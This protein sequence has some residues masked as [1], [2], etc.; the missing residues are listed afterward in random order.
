MPT[1]DANNNIVITVT[2]IRGLF[3]EF[4]DAL[5]YPDVRVQSCITVA[6]LY[7]STKNY[8]DIGYDRRVLLIELMTAHLLKL[9]DQT[10]AGT[11]GGAVGAGGATGLKTHATI[12]E[13]SV[14]YAIPEDNGALHYF[15]N[16]TTYGQRYGAFLAALVSPKLYGGSYQRLL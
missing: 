3:P 14:S 11:S 7:V 16:Q 4:S 9:D 8:G 12:G 13:V 2:D 5:K 6:G 1:L 15:L 10:G